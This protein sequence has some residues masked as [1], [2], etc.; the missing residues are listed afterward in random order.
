MILLGFPPFSWPPL[1]QRPVLS[2]AGLG[3]V[4]CGTGSPISFVEGKKVV[5]WAPEESSP[6]LPQ[7]LLHLEASGA[8]GGDNGRDSLGLE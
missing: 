5:V 7:V 4:S 2:S 1:P 8:G 6:H 3:R